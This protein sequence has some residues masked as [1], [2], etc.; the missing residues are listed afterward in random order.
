MSTQEV[1]RIFQDRH[2]LVLNQPDCE[3]GKFSLKTLSTLRSLDAQL[4][5]Q[6][7]NELA[8]CSLLPFCSLFSQ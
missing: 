8:H 3:N 5:M 1:Q 2:I 4:E 7:E 6:G